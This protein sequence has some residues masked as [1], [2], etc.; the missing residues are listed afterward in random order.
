[1]L[2]F[3]G[4]TKVFSTPYFVI[5]LICISAI[6]VDFMGVFKTLKLLKLFFKFIEK[7]S[8]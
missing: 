8:L 4:V 3:R 6:S 7:G 5:T 2:N 1:M